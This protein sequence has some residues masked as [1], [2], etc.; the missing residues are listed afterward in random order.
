MSHLP[1]PAYQ[2]GVRL[3]G[4]WAYLVDFSR[5]LNLVDVGD[6]TEP[7]LRSRIL[8]DVRSAVVRDDLAFIAVGEAGLRI[9]D[10]TDPESPV[11]AG[12]CDLTGS[13]WDLEVIGDLAHVCT[14]HEGLQVVDISDPT[15]PVRRGGIRIEREYMMSMAIV[16]SYAYVPANNQH[17]H[18]FDVS[19]PDNPTLA[20]TYPMNCLGEICAAGSRLYLNTFDENFMNG[21]TVLDVTERLAPVVVGD[22]RMPGGCRDV[23]VD[24]QYLIVVTGASLMVL[25]REGAWVDESVDRLGHLGLRVSNPTSVAARIR[26]DLPMAGRARL[27]LLDVSGR[28]LATLHDAMMQAGPGLLEW[29]WRSAGLPSGIY[30]VRLRAAGREASRAVTFVR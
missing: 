16:D 13:A 11:L 17:L 28:H 6:P 7:V 18:V 1:L 22:L 3:A 2:R 24:D 20:L 23:L 26:L 12:Q 29:D 10:L 25:D 21:I 15:Q 4:D 27:D 19:D 8:D 30:F 9:Y 5:A 14:F